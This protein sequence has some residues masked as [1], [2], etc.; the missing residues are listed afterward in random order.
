MSSAGTYLWF[1]ATD[2]DVPRGAVAHAR[3]TPLDRGSPVHLAAWPEPARPKGVRVA[4]IAA[5]FVDPAGDPATVLLV[6]VPRGVRVPFDDQ[7][8]IGARRAS[9]DYWPWRALS[10]LVRGDSVFAGA[11][12]AIGAG[13]PVPGDP[14]AR[15]AP[16]RL[17][18]VPAGFVGEMPMPAGPVLERYGSAKPWPVE[19]F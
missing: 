10:T 1:A 12:S 14:F 16:V 19:R 3:A 6:I 13:E 4:K 17:L 2:G 8:V 15:I 18:S 9:L 5:E 11:V 7:S